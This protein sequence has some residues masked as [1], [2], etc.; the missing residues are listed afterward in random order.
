MNGNTFI[1]LAV[2]TKTSHFAIKSEEFN[3]RGNVSFYK[4]WISGGRESS[5]P[6]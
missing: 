1:G 3:A 2:F 5:V 4:Q 6:N